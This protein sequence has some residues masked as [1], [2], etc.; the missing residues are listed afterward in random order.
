MAAGRNRRLK[1]IRRH[2]LRVAVTTVVLAASS[3]WQSSGFTGATPQSLRHSWRSTDA[4]SLAAI[5]PDSGAADDAVSNEASQG[6]RRNVL[7]ASVA[8]A[9]GAFLALSF[10]PS[11]PANAKTPTFSFGSGNKASPAE[12]INGSPIAQ[13]LLETLT[14]LPPGEAERRRKSPTD[15]LDKEKWYVKSFRNFRNSC[16]G[17]HPIQRDAPGD[18]Q[19]LLTNDYFERR[20][21]YDEKRVQ[22]S[23]RYGVGRMPGYAADCGDLNDNY[24]GQCNQVTPLSEDQ[25]RDLQDFIVNRA[26][27]DWK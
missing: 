17:C 22:Y 26:N 4:L 7:G 20:G 12:L 25:L 16:A 5:D 21:G 15:T 2:A 1:A 19:A 3:C 10:M 6:S 8:A 9:A 14:P 18:Y 11:R 13:D 24:F 23:I 27:S